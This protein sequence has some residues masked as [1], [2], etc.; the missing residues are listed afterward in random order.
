QILNAA[1]AEFNIVKSDRLADHRRVLPGQRQHVVIHVH[2]DDAPRRPH[3]LRGDK[4]NLPG[5]AA[6]IQNGFSM[7]EMFGRVAAAIV[8]VDDFLWND[9]Q[10][11]T[12]VFD[13]T[14]KGL[15][16]L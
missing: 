12:I 14:T 16:S 8:V 2:A 13:G 5:S 11:L 7:L 3:N 1:F 10:K 4:T 9:L 15:D 6:D